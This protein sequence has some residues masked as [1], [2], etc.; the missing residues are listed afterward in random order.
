MA[1]VVSDLPRPVRVIE[2]TWIP[3]PDG[4]RLAAKIWLPQDAEGDPLP[5][6]LK[7]SITL[8]STDDRYADDVHY[9][10]GLVLAMDMLHWGTYMLLANAEPPEPELA[11]E[12]WREM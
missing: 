8:C 2:N 5:A 10:G 12:R 1:T 6:A 11:G 3:L 9:K 4:T 7:A